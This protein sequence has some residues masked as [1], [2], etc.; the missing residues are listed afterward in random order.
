[1]TVFGL[2]GFLL[3]GALAGWAAA[4]L[5]RGRGFGLGGNMA[6]GVLGSLVGGWLLP[7]LGVKVDGHGFVTAFVGALVL[8]F[9]LGLWRGKS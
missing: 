6:V 8:L 4:R 1:M 3:I 2:L 5:L 7:Q 9:V